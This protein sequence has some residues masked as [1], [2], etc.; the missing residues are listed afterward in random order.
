MNVSLPK[1]DSG[2]KII[3]HNFCGLDCYLIVPEIDAKWTKN[4]LHYRSLIVNKE[5]EVL[6]SGW[7]KFFNFGE[8]PECYP[9][10]EEFEDWVVQ[11]K[12][13]GSLVI[14]DYVNNHFSLRTRGAASYTFQKNFKDFELL[15][16]HYPQLKPFLKENAHLSLL[17]EIVTPN[18]IIVLR[19]EAIQFYFLGAVDKRSLSIVPNVNFPFDILTPKQY[20]FSKLSNI[21]EAVRHWKGQEGIVLSY[22]KGSNRIKV[23]SSWYCWI[24]R[25]KSQLNS[26][27]NLIEL[28]VNE[29]MP[30]YE[31]FYKIIETNF[32]FELAE[33]LKKDLKRISEAG[34]EVKLKLEKIQQLVSYLQKL[35]TRKEQAAVI[36][37][38][39]QY[40]NSELVSI[41]FSFLDNKQIS[42]SVLEK[43]IGTQLLLK[44]TS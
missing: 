10:P 6:S 30:C 24:H 17:F 13:D 19:S 16:E 36:L 9:N 25:I 35:K 33:Q 44:H 15:T 1:E 42:C 22:N 27:K 7:P 34:N 23:K 41:A 5:G 3:P 39:Y 29:Q 32:D 43:L 38:S 28:Y 26:D 20:N 4:N 40:S 2:F 8:K 14:C 37:D 18:N 31:T 12:I 11:E 21:I